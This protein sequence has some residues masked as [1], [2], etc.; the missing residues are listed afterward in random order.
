MQKHISNLYV[1]T[2][3][4]LLGKSS[5]LR[6][7]GCAVLCLFIDAAPSIFLGSAE[8]G[9]GGW[10]IWAVII[11]GGLGSGHYQIPK[12]KLFGISYNLGNSKCFLEST[13]IYSK[14]SGRSIGIFLENVCH[15]FGFFWKFYRFPYPC[16]Q[17]N[18]LIGP[19]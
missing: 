4:I 10:N 15:I 14:C 12:K 1:R 18:R 9:Q 7:V 5:T 17:G 2:K 13:L 8:I 6:A 11:L 16:G 3:S 19:H